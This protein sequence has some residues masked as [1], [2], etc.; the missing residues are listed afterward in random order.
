VFG[1]G[2][3]HG[4]PSGW[5]GVGLATIYGLM[6]GVVRLRT[7]GLLAAWIAHVA[8]DFTIACLILTS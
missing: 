8:A 3:L 5:I 4:F 2:H 1:V 7:G 6:L